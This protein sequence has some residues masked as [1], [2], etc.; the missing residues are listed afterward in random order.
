MQYNKVT[1]K[2]KEH[3]VKIFTLSTCGWCKKTK[4]LL[5]A[6]DVAYEFVDVDKLSG[7]ELNEAT[8]EIKKYNSRMSYPTIVIDGGKHVIVGYKD[9][10][11][12]EVLS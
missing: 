4:D 6:I 11:I 8:D 9:E 2:N 5:K 1:G 10:H 12:L 7:K 3:E